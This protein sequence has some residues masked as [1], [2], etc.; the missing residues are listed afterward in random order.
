MRFFPPTFGRTLQPFLLPPPFLPQGSFP[1][2]VLFPFLGLKLHL[3]KSNKCP[4]VGGGGGTEKMA[5]LRRAKMGL[6]CPVGCRRRRVR[7]GDNG[8]RVGEGGRKEARR[9]RQKEEEEEAPLL[10]YFFLLL[11]LCAPLI[12]VSTF[13]SFLL[14]KAPLRFFPPPPPLRSRDSKEK[15][16]WTAPLRRG[17]NVPRGE[18]KDEKSFFVL[19]RRP[20]LGPWRKPREA[21]AR[22]AIGD[23]W[24]GGGW[25]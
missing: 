10:F 4:F 21:S 16:C 18:E 25:Q 24:S 1:L 13:P 2:S 15:D 14:L 12:R 7:R 20:F 9:K 8:R 11:F 5:Q 22:A 3:L 6:G 17:R 19:P 23:A